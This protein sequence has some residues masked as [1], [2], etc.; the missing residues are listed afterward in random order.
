MKK[1]RTFWLKWSM[2]AVV[3]AVFIGMSI[4]D[5]GFW[6]LASLIVV[7]LIVWPFMEVTDA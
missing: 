2:L 3:S 4:T 6:L 1:N 5:P 7:S